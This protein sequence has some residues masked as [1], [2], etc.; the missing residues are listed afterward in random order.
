MKQCLL[1]DAYYLKEFISLGLLPRWRSTGMP[2]HTTLL[3]CNYI[4]HL[5]IDCCTHI[6]A[7]CLTVHSGDSTH[8]REIALFAQKNGC[9]LDEASIELLARRLIKPCVLTRRASIAADFVWALDSMKRAATLTQTEIASLNRRWSSN[10]S[11]V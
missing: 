10:A 4:E 2:C 8:V 5:G 3:A 6:K 7:E 1:V 9:S 11:K